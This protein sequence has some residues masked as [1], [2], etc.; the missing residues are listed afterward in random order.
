MELKS[1]DFCSRDS[2]QYYDSTLMLFR[3]SFFKKHDLPFPLN[4]YSTLISC[5]NKHV[6]LSKRRCL[7]RTVP[8]FRR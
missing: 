3:L 4:I 6:D 1:D 2:G 5:S 8:E 7:H